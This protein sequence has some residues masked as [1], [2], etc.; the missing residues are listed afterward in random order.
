VTATDLEAAGG[1]QVQMAGD[2]RRCDAAVGGAT[3]NSSMASF[4]AMGS[5]AL[6]NLTSYWRKCCGFSV[7]AAGSRGCGDFALRFVD[8]SPLEGSGFELPV[9]LQE[10]TAQGR[11][12]QRVANRSPSGGA[13]A[14]LIEKV[15]CA[16]DSPPSGIRTLGP[17]A[18]VEL[19]S[20]GGARR[21][22]CQLNHSSVQPPG[23][24]DRPICHISA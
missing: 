24:R 17:P 15:R 13:G 12:D 21:D 7:P 16:A 20:A 1:G 9:P 23:H 11:S 3:G 8:D 5:Y 6:P 2:Q 22:R 19:G 10:N 14:P 4:A 18:T